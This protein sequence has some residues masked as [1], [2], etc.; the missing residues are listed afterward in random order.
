MRQP[1]IAIVLR[2]RPD[3]YGTKKLYLR[4]SFN[5]QTNYIA[6]P[7]K[8]LPKE[9]DRKSQTVKP[10][11]KIGAKGSAVVN[12]D[13]R[14]KLNKAFLITTE[15]IAADIYP[16]FELFRQKFEHNRKQHEYFAAAAKAVLQKEIAAKEITEST[17]KVYLTSL[18]R[19]TKI[20]GDISLQQLTHDK[21]LHFKSKLIAEDKE[22]LASQY[23]RNLS[24]MYFKILK[25]H[26]L[27]DV[28][29]PFEFVEIKVERISEKKQLS[30]EEYYTLRK[31][32]ANYPPGSS[33]HET[34]RRFL[35]M[36]RGLRYSD[37][38]EI[39]KQ[40]HYFE[41]Q[42]KDTVYRYLLMAA[43]K[44][45]SEEI[46]PISEDD[47]IELMLWQADGFLFKKTE[48]ATYRNRLKKIA[49]KLIGRT[50]TTHFGRH[51]TGDMIL[52]SGMDMEDVKKIL[53][54]KSNRIAE[55]YAKKN[56]K[57][58]LDRFYAAVAAL[59]KESK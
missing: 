18:N 1:S 43:K 45:G 58:V 14:T 9:W 38:Q 39:N 21:I 42:E 36:C 31:A 20:V 16:T 30:I 19:F 13:L 57:S 53:G 29:N 26:R 3:R 48:Y 28:N 6:L 12:M 11:A 54:V 46:V 49:Q 47:A 15:L 23:L 59:D 40:E 2:G 51:F 35:M 56:I 41:F 50:I 8:V 7:W 55:V 34:I 4:Y 27:K 22:N 5:Y 10:S 24:S 52:N 32:L 25:F 17:A 44:S 37:T 33:E